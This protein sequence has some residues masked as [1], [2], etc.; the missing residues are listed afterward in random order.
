MEVETIV[1]LNPLII[2]LNVYGVLFM[3]LLNYEEYYP[4][5]TIYLIFKNNIT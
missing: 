4:S 5:F 1:W 3:I 2:V